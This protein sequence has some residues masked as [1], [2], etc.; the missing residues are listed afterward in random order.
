MLYMENQMEE[1]LKWKWKMKLIFF[2]QIIF[3][4][5]MDETINSIE[6][7]NS[8]TNLSNFFLHNKTFLTN[9]G[10]LNLYQ[11]NKAGF[12]LRRMKPFNLISSL[13][14]ILRKYKC[15]SNPVQSGLSISS[16]FSPYQKPQRKTFLFF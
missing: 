9:L 12:F 13:W 1:Y 10:F 8:R 3:Q 2:A 5:K 4:R 11:N 7:T 14:F 6:I 16:N 15:N